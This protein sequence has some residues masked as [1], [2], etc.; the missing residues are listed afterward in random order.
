[1]CNDA[2]LQQRA[3]SKGKSQLEK[4]FAYSSGRAHELD[5][6]QHMQFSDEPAGGAGLGLGLGLGLGTA[7]A[8]SQQPTQGVKRSRE[9]AGL[10]A[11]AGAGSGSAGSDSDARPGKRAKTA[12]ESKAE[13][14]ADPDGDVSMRTTSEDSVGLA[15]VCVVCTRP[16]FNCRGRSCRRDDLLCLLRSIRVRSVAVPG[17]S[18]CPL[19]LS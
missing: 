18:R 19:K 17:V 4:V 1:M 16:L 3:P 7:H 8:P 10:D 11:G 15:A 14:E 2:G 13:S 5:P 9:E 6:R 12:T